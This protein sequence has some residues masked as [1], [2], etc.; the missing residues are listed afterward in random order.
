MRH[1][2]PEIFRKPRHLEGE[3]PGLGFGFIGNDEN[4]IRDQKHLYPWLLAR[5]IAFPARV[6]VP[7]KLGHKT[8][9]FSETTSKTRFTK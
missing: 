8:G 9:I 7:A 4:F 1:R 2:V 5:W 3:T 6:P